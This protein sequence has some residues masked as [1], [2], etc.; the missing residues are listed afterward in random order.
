MRLATWGENLE[1]R[2]DEGVDGG[3]AEDVL[4]DE[5]SRGIFGVCRRSH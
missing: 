5:Q 4:E 1:P 2:L 3:I